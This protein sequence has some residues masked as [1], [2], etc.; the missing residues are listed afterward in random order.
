[1]T[2]TTRPQWTLADRLHK[3]R[4][5]AGLSQDELS[6]R[7][8]VGV[9]SIS[10]YESGQATPRRH[11]LLAWALATGVDPGWLE[12]TCTVTTEYPSAA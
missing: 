5:T 7:I 8:E 3:C 10:R 11:V 9:R 12:D 2:T 6:E 4:T 1:M